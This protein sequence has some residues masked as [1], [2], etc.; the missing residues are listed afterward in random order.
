MQQ[1]ADQ[2][3]TDNEGF[4]RIFSL[5]NK[6]DLVIKPGEVRERD[7]A[8]TEDGRFYV[9]YRYRD[10]WAIFQYYVA[11]DYP[12][13]M[14]SEIALARSIGPTGH[15]FFLD[16]TM[17]A[18]SWFLAVDFSERPLEMTK[19]IIERIATNGLMVLN[20]EPLPPAEF[21]RQHTG[22]MM[23]RRRTHKAKLRSQIKKTGRPRFR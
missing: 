2:P 1:N 10:T 12:F 22:M 20:G 23:M 15:R 6:E 16:W 19:A 21:I 5:A 9:K 11:M 8:Q 4:N 13:P 3:L 17:E 14:T 7:F 18:E